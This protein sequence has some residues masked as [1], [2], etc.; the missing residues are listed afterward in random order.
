MKEAFNYLKELTGIEASR[1]SLS[2]RIVENLPIYITQSY[3]LQEAVLFNR[4]IVFAEQTQDH[5]TVSQIAKHL[6]V[7]KKNLD[8]PVV[9]VLKNM[10]SYNRKRFIENRINF[11]VPEKQIFLP[12]LL[13]SLSENFKIEKDYKS[14]KLMPS[15]Q[16]LLIF[17]LLNKNN[18][19]KLEQKS[20]KEIAERLDYTPMAIS[21]AVDE[22]KNYN[23]ID[24]LGDREK[25]IRFSYKKRALWNYALEKDLFESPILK[26]IY[27]DDIPENIFMLKAGISALS[28]YTR[29]NPDRQQYYAV[30]K[31]EFYKLQKNNVFN[32]SSD[33]EGRYAIEV[34]KYDPKILAAESKNNNTSVD[35]LSLYLSIK[36]NCDER[37]EM[38][39]EQ[40]IDEIIW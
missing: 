35:P 25:H 1:S 30:E 4:N 17:H 20:F 32:N 29:L 22:L 40:L 10:Q 5:F 16:F 26:T 9:L 39:L 7:I 14:K 15:S 33:T 24:V 3:K 28:Q 6:Q 13:I 12:E 37:I 23:L 18:N 11:I 38:G 21:Y 2:S 8:K 34:W 36:N 19:W 27:T 31:R